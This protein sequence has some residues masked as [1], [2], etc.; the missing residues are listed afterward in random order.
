MYRVAETCQVLRPAR[1]IRESGLLPQLRGRKGRLRE[2]MRQ[3]H[4]PPAGRCSY[5]GIRL[6]ANQ[7]PEVLPLGKPT[8]KGQRKRGPAGVGEQF[9]KEMLTGAVT[10]MRGRMKGLNTVEWLHRSPLS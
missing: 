9:G 3:A 1:V 4:G 6:R 7:T 5:F 10:G 8:S 2:V